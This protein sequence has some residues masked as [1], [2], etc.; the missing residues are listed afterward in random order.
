MAVVVVKN[1]AYWAPGHLVIPDQPGKPII[2]KFKARFRRL[3]E[4]ERK[5]L[6]ARMEA[7]RDYVRAVGRAMLEGKPAPVQPQNLIT[8]RDLL[9]QVMT[10]WEG[11]HNGDGSVAIYTPAARHQVT[12]D[13]PGLEQAMARAY[14]ESRD[15]AQDLAAVEKNSEAP[16]ATT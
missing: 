16:S 6:D 14:L 3:N 4:A 2:F 11:F 5:E 13:T 15:P 12:F 1:P 7:G 8:D 9:D 10:D